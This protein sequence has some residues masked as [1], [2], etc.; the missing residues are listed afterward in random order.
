[1]SHATPPPLKVARDIVKKF[2]L[3]LGPRLTPEQRREFARLVT[4]LEEADRYYMNQLVARGRVEPAP[5]RRA[6]GY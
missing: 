5:A 1:M 3:D 4:L 2:N 6:Q